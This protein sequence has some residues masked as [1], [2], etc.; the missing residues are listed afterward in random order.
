VADG[1][2]SAGQLVAVGGDAGC[3]DDPAGD[4]G[5]FGVGEVAV[6]GCGAYGAVPHV[7]GRYPPCLFGSQAGV[8]VE[9][10]GELGDGGVGV[11]AGVGAPAMS[12]AATMCGS[13]CSSRRPGPKR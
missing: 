9:S 12:Q 5:P 10:A 13:V 3:G 2:P 11:A 8:Q 6:A 1:D 7:L 4:R